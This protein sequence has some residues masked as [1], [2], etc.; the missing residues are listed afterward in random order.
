MMI[1]YPNLVFVSGEII[2]LATVEGVSLN[3][4]V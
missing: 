2:G 4:S 1:W 3:A